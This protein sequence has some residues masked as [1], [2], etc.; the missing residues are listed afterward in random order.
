M[1]ERRVLMA[2][3]RDR[4]FSTPGMDDTFSS[5]AQVRAMLTFEAALARAEAR[6]GIIPKEAAEAIAASCQGAQF[7]VSALYREAAV[8]GTLAIPLVRRLTALVT[9]EA[10]PF[11]HWGATSQDALDTALILQMRAGLQQ[12]EEG[13]LGVCAGCAS[14]AEQHR[15]TLMAGRTLLQQALPI[16]FGL[17][18]ARWLDLTARQVRLLREDRERH[19]AV[20]LGGAAGTL[21]ALGAQ[22][23]QVVALLAEELGLAARAL[24]WHTERDRV[25]HIAASLGVVAGAMAKIAGDVL[26]LAQTEVGEAAEAAAPGRGIS[27]ALPQKH[28]P[29][30][31]TFAAA[32]ARL[33]I[34]L[35]PVILSAMAQEHERAAGGWQAE[36]SALPDLFR[37]TA[38]AVWHVREA[39]G[40]LQIDV[41]R[42]QANLDQAGG[43][44][45][46][47]SLTMAL[48][49]QLGRPKA[50]QM[51]RA[52]CE[53]AVQEGMSLRQI[54][55]TN[56][57]VRAVLSPEAI[58]RALDPRSY[59]GSTE[60]FITR[61]LE[62]YR[63]V[64]TGRGEG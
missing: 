37:Y 40:G 21:A 57:E 19:L 62:A 1:A 22:G 35:V 30:A 31:A 6:A 7:E 17:K 49:P 15:Q 13:L 14:L 48:A 59:L 47:E 44:L 27:S 24:P 41:G 43:L 4:F 26:L 29:I 8:A 28:N 60:T 36:W 5:E 23:T 10:Q 25:A 54:A 52:M 63:Q 42:M 53:Q 61:A 12:L 58:E 45:M 51:V 11:V 55:L 39:V 50:Q 18:A 56:A 3:P 32:S 34:G 33:A 38:G 2:E 46:A 9:E 64:Q 20:Q 16:T